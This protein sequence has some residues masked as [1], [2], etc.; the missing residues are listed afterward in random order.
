VREGKIFQI[1]FSITAN[2]AYSKTKFSSQLQSKLQIF[3]IKMSKFS[4]NSNRT[5]KVNPNATFTKFSP[6][7]TYDEP[8]ATF[9]ADPNRTF[10]VS[11]NRTY[12]AVPNVTFDAAM[13]PAASYQTHLSYEEKFFLNQL[14]ILC[15]DIRSFITAMYKFFCDNYQFDCHG[16]RKLVAEIDTT[17]QTIINEIVVRQLEI[18]EVMEAT[19][20][21]S[22]RYEDSIFQPSSLPYEDHNQQSGQSFKNQERTYHNISNQP[23]NRLSVNQR[24]AKSLIEG[25]RNVEQTERNLRRFKNMSNLQHLFGLADDNE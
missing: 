10:A 14:E 3:P 11:L 6:N 1:K 7:Q 13:G 15:T 19:R 25:L 17:A 5:F 21:E 16:V 20:E 4:R 23:R 2:N 9:K 18:E 22:G 24:H 12:D 8:N